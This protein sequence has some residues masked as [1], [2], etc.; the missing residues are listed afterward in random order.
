[1]GSKV[2]TARFV[3]A[4]PSP[5]GVEPGVVGDD[6]ADGDEDRA[7][8]GDT[9]VG[10]YVTADGRLLTEYEQKQLEAERHRRK[11]LELLASKPLAKFCS[12]E[13]S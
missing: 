12:Q 9:T 5:G 1:M 10:S 11:S 6:T 3:R 8:G 4:G 7:L 13:L 2:Q